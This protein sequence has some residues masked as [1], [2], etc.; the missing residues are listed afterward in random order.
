MT[1]KHAL[2][3][4]NNINPHA[5]N[6]QHAQHVNTSPSTKRKM[7]KQNVKTFHNKIQS[8]D[9]S[10]RDANSSNRSNNLI[11]MTNL[12][13]NVSNPGICTGSS[14]NNN[15]NINI[16]A[17]INSN[18]NKVRKISNIH[19]S[20]KNNNCAVT[21]GNVSSITTRQQTVLIKT[22]FMFLYCGYIS[23]DL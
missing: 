8:N 18:L 4:V 13:N 16:T 6:A 7:E 19:T 21:T 23:P 5:Q 3:N 2:I 14:S 12:T 17:T 9:Y 22:I 1:I 15:T 10:Y 11:N 20:G